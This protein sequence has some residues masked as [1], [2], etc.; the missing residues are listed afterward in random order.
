MVSSSRVSADWRGCRPAAKPDSRSEHGFGPA[1][2]MVSRRFCVFTKLWNARARRVLP[3]GGG[4]ENRGGPTALFQ[5][6][7]MVKM[8]DADPVYLCEK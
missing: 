1:E 4:S 5:V 8:R 2:I 7:A 6:L 3:G